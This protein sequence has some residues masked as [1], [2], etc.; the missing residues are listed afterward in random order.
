MGIGIKLKQYSYYT[1]RPLI[2]EIT[3][4]TMCPTVRM[5]QRKTPPDPARHGRYGGKWRVNEDDTISPEWPSED[6]PFNDW[7]LVWV[8]NDHP[9]AL[10]ADGQPTPSTFVTMVTAATAK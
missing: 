6:E 3:P 10:N 5:I 7:I 4:G 2:N 8:K 9:C 1:I